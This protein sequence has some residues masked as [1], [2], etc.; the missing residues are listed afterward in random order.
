MLCLLIISLIAR[1][2]TTEGD[3]QAN[4]GGLLIASN[5]AQWTVPQGNQGGYSWSSPDFCK[6]NYAGATFNA[7]SNGTPVAIVDTGNPN[8]SETV[9]VLQFNSTAGGC[10]IQVNPTHVHNTFFFRSATAGLGEALAFAG[11]Q[12][13]Q[14]ILTPNF[15][16]LGG[17]TATVTSAHGNANVTILDQRSAV[18][19]PYLWNG[20]AYVANPFAGGVSPGGTTGAV[21]YNAAGSFGGFN[22]T[23]LLKLNGAG[24]PTIAT[25]GTDY[26]LPNASTTGSSGSLSVASALPNG[27]TATTQ[28][29]GDSTT[30][31]ATD[32]FVIANQSTATIP[33]TS[34][35]LKGSGS[36]GAAAIATPGTDYVAP[37]TTVNGHA[38]S[39]NVVVSASDL[40]TGTLPHAQLPTLISGDIPNNAASTSS[41]A[42]NLSGTPTLPNG[43]LGITQPPGDNT[44]RLATDAFVLANGGG[45]T[46]CTAVVNGIQYNNG[47]SFGCNASL[48]FNPSTIGLT[49]GALGVANSGANFN[50]GTFSSCGSYWTGSAPALGCATIQSQ[51]GTGV[52]PYMNTTFGFSNPGGGQFTFPYS[53]FG[54]GLSIVATDGSGLF[55]F[56]PPASITGG[57]SYSISMPEA[58]PTSGNGFLDC[59]ASTSSVCTWVAGGGGGGGSPF[60]T[61]QGFGGYG[62]AYSP[63]DGCITTA[64]NTTINC[65]GPFTS[66][67]VDG[68]KDIWVHGA[69][70]AGVAFHS[71]IVSVT[72]ANHAVMAA[73]PSISLTNTPGNMVYGHDDATAVQACW[74][75][76]STNAVQCA[77]AAQ[78]T[79]A[80]GGLTGYLIGSAGLQLVSNNADEEINGTNTIG[81]GA[82]FGSNLFCEFNGDCV[83]LAPGPIEYAK[84][85]D[86]SLI[87]DPSQPNGRGFDFNASA[88]TYGNGGLWFSTFTNIQV[89]NFNLEC[90]LSNGGAYNTGGELPN[91]VDTFI[92]FNCNAPPN[93][94]HTA[95]LIKMI[96]QHAQI[97]FINGQTNGYGPETNQPNAM[98]LITEKTTGQADSATDVKFYGYTYEVGEIG[99]Q[100]GN[101]A[102]NI[103]YD[104]GYVENVAQPLIAGGTNGVFGL[105][106][107]G[108][109]IA[110]SGNVT[111]VAQFTGNVTGSMHDMLAYGGAGPAAALAICTNTGNQID[112][113]SGNNVQAPGVN[114]VTGC[115]PTISVSAAGSPLA[116]NTCTSG[117]TVT[118]PGL[119]TSAR[120]NIT[121]SGDPTGIT[122][123][124]GTGGMVIQGWPSAQNTATYKLCNQSN[125]GI[126]YGAITF[127]VG[128]N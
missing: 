109:H 18:I 39:A 84:M 57:I 45:G 12:L 47:G 49:L 9:T 114:T 41:T 96:G 67:L 115:N 81:G 42:A 61:P 83:S 71:T 21:Q 29:T 13:Y 101:G 125:A 66:T 86:I 59:S 63:P 17:L 97:V 104:N 31:V 126:T 55:S 69:G 7:F 118:V 91:Q 107:N 3:S 16:K 50:S 76:A 46:P 2:Q 106:Y 116:A 53:V 36:A 103:H 127:N 48:T 64:S 10:S 32:A 54:L 23:G 98:I 14:V 124:G 58:A 40:T 95:N 117:S 33:A 74:Q 80:G 92:N 65:N 111:G 102:Y 70:A 123:W 68:G 120:L 27:T 43:T 78:P 38:L 62:D 85:S 22:G 79:P 90:M 110:N 73:A 1:G 11:Q 37:S 56:H 15:T 5:F 4:I 100:L 75:Y 35:V 8:N 25:S 112:F 113:G 94:V 108:N 44:A 6:S 24:A 82:G 89:A 30:K 119:Y 34:N 52:N 122:G 121:Y 128:F 77:L 28:T 51:M 20:T 87:G 72:D 88:G 26:A 93:Q 19:V 105:T 99:L 60:V